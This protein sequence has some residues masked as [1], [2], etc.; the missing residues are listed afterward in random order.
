[1]GALFYFFSSLRI[2]LLNVHDRPTFDGDIGVS[3]SAPGGAV[4]QVGHKVVCFF[5]QLTHML[6]K[7]PT[8]T[9]KAGQLMNG[10]SMSCPSASGAVALVISALLASKKAYTPV[11][12][13][14]AL[15]NSSLV[16]AHLQPFDHGYGLLQVVFLFVFY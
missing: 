8:W 7:V 9:L 16:D 2:K 12:L 5:S 6:R 15:E 10:T 11:S 3:L 13:R 4:T 14:R 1:V